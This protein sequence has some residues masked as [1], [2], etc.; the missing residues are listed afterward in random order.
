MIDTL[1]PRLTNGDMLP[2]L[3]LP[4]VSGESVSLR[5]FIDGA[6]AVVLFY[7]GNWCPF[8]NAQ[9]NA[10]QRKLADFEAIGVRVIAISADTLEEARKTVDAHHIAYPV[11]YGAE[12]AAVAQSFG[13][14]TAANA[15]GAYVNSTGFVVNP[16]GEIVV[17]VYSTGAIGRI[18]A[19]DALGFVKYLQSQA[20]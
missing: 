10:F 3:T 20:R 1:G 9:L 19:D 8:C 6:Y 14:H 11:L 5:S 17:A 15:R 13:T 18:T 16:K 2:D 4:G 12:P 7:R